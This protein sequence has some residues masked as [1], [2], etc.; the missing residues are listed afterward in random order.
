MPMKKCFGFAGILLI[1]T[2]LLLPVTV[3]AQ[4]AGQEVKP[5]SI[6]AT[7]FLDIPDPQLMWG[8][9]TGSDVTRVATGKLDGDNTDDVVVLDE[10]TTQPDTLTAYTGSGTK[11][12]DFQMAG[13][14]V[15]IGDIDGDNLNE[16]V[17][18]GTSVE[19]GLGIYAFENSGPGAGNTPKWFFKTAG[20]V[21]DIKIGNVDGDANGINE[22]I[23][24]DDYY[25]P[26]TI[27]VL[28]G[29]NGTSISGWPVNKPGED[30]VRVAI[31]QLDGSRGV[32]IA[33]I[34]ER[35]PTTLMVFHDNGTLYWQKEISGRCV[36]IGDINGDHSNEVVAGTYDGRVIAYTSSGQEFRTFSMENPVYV[37]DLV[38]G[39]LDGNPANG[40]EAACID[41]GAGTLYALD[42]D[43]LP[44]PA[45][46]WRAPISWSSNYS[47]NL[48]DYCYGRGLA[49]GD[50]DHD[51]QNEVV[52]LS[53]DGYVYAFDGKDNSGD[54]IGDMVWAP[55]QIVSEWLNYLSDI[56]LGDFNA[57]GDM[58]AAVGFTAMSEGPT[59]YGVA[60]LTAQDSYVALNGPADR[61]YFDA[62]PSNINDL[63][64]IP[65]S[66]L[67][68]GPT[69]PTNYIYPYGFFQFVVGQLEES[70]QIVTITVTFPENVPIGAKWIKYQNGSWSVLNIGDDDGDNVITYQIT[71]GGVGDADGSANGYIEEPGGLGLPMIVQGLGGEVSLV[72]KAKVFL[73]WLAAVALFSLGGVILLVSRRKGS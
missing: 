40:I 28:N 26:G 63:Q 56:A 53:Y 10:C 44:N 68:A 48:D 16:V 23:A 24:C 32:D 52:A 67:P 3:A 30:W 51:Y 4:P 36:E 7:H 19:T 25:A 37:T 20:I 55:Y 2:S 34:S 73:P 50:I 5:L 17:A 31:G 38:L 72:N 15:A 33:V 41:G 43:A 45:V 22:V 47:Y 62:D 29:V 35:T 59:L 12:W 65:E 27:F 11:L 14:A 57:D 21:K 58:D 64:P 18:A 46:L 70:R 71:D 60:A 66:T 13:Y 49:I 54:R 39:D 1:I 9:P 42:M 61:V 6:K 69:K 8:K